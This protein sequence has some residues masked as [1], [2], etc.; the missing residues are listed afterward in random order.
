MMMETEE[1]TAEGWEEMLELEWDS[2]KPQHYATE[3]HEFGRQQTRLDL[4][5]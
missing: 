2:T 4:L 5:Q 3:E 1:D